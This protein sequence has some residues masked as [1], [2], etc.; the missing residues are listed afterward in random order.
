[1]NHQIW[2]S[3]LFSEK[4]YLLCCNQHIQHQSH[5]MHPLKTWRLKIGYPE[6]YHHLLKNCHKFHGYPHV[7]MF[8]QTMSCSFSESTRINSWA[9]GAQQTYRSCSCLALLSMNVEYVLHIVYIY[10]RIIYKYIIIIRIYIYIYV[11][12]KIYMYILYMGGF[13]KW[14]CPKTTGFNTKIV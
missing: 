11:C 14:W 10:M 13:L 1:M 3:P 6:A 12:K 8:G 5:Q 9:D 4:P 2:E 7:S